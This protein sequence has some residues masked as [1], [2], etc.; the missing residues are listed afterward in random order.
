MS[1]FPSHGL[2]DKL[3]LQNESSP[4]KGYDLRLTGHSLGAGIAACLG[5]LLKSK[6][7]QL[8]CSCFSPPGCSISLNMAESST[9]FIT[10]YILDGDIIPRMSV[11]SMKHLREDVAEMV[12]RIVSGKNRCVHGIG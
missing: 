2:L 1:Y 12:A 3:L 11:E 4:V 10:S 5:F 6:F 7:Q 9:N 8:K